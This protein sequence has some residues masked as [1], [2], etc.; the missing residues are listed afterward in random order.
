MKK[1]L[2]TL[3]LVTIVT[4]VSFARVPTRESDEEL[5][6]EMASATAALEQ[7][8]NSVFM[9][10]DEKVWRNG[11]YECNKVKVMGDNDKVSHLG[12]V[13]DPRGDDWE[14][15]N[16]FYYEVKVVK[17][18]PRVLNHKGF[19]VKH[20]MI[21]EWDLIVFRNAKGA[22]VD[23][24]IGSDERPRYEDLMRDRQA[25]LNGVWVSARGDTASLGNEPGARYD[26]CPGAYQLEETENGWQILFAHNRMKVVDMPVVTKKEDPQTGVITYYGDGK[27]ISKEEYEFIMSR[28]CGYGGHGALLGP[29]V[30]DIQP[31][32]DLKKIDVK[33]T[34]PYDKEQDFRVSPFDEEQFTL[35]WVRSLYPG[36]KGRW[37][38]ASVRPLTRRMLRDVSKSGLRDLLAD[39]NSRQGKPAVMSAVEKLNKSLVTTMLSEK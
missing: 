10:D 38:V 28:P 29:I 22:V 16:P 4:A 6:R 26:G 37:A 30:W 23:V 20:Q 11:D 15:N 3:L 9:P 8:D 31:S 36:M 1:M 14:S 35:S 19:T 34:E 7:G 33:L 12:F 24:L 32:A 27:P 2:M 18:V 25:M 21:G 39:L 5:S 17:G 13:T